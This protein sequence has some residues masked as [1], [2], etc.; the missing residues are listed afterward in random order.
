MHPDFKLINRTISGLKAL[1]QSMQDMF[2]QT[3]QLEEQT[4]SLCAALKTEQ[5]AD[6]LKEIP[7]EDLKNSR[8]G[9]RTQL[10]KEA[11]FHSLHDLWLAGDDELYALSGIGEKQ[12]QAI[13]SITGTFL[14]H[15][16][17]RER[18]RLPKADAAEKGTDRRGDE[19]L[20]LLA[21]YRLAR[22]ICRD[23]KVPFDKH[24]VLTNE[25]IGRIKIRGRLRWLFSGARA[26][27]E[28]LA[29]WEELDAYCSGP[30][31]ERI[32]RFC[33]LYLEAVGISAEDA[34]ADY[35]KN[36]AAYYALL[37]KI[38]G[39]EP[40][41]R[42]VYGSLPQQLAEQVSGVETFLD[43]FRGDLRPY[44]HFGVQYVLH[45]KKVLLGDEMGLGK[46]IQAVGVMVHLNNL[47]E[48][49]RFLIVCP[50]S[51]MANWCREIRKF[52]QI[53]AWLLH[54]PGLEESFSAWEEKGGA[55]VTNYESL[56]RI[57]D[58]IDEHLAL[59]LLVVDEAHYIKNPDAQRTRFL[60][61]LTDESQRILLMSGTPLENKVDEM[62]ELIGFV[63]PDL[64]EKVR[65][66]AGPGRSEEFRE[67]LS[68]G[69]LRRQASQVLEE[70]P[71]LIENEEWCSMTPD[72]TAAYAL[73]ITA[74]NFMGM[75]RVSF[76]SDDAADSSKAQRLSELCSQALEDNK[77]VIVYS[78][79]R[80]TLRKAAA[81]L[82]GDVTGEITGST[83]PAQRQA[84]I[85]RF[86]DTP[87]GSILLCQTQAGGTGLNIQA[88][89]VVIFCEP[90]IK[91]SLE[92]QAI[93]RVY[94]MGQTSSVLVFHL[95]CENTVDE[96]IRILLE[97]KEKE[98]SLYADE[99]AMARAEASLADREWIR[100]VVD[101][102]RSRY[103]PAVY[104]RV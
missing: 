34:R 82:G 86:S 47:S 54:G 36:S 65:T 13:R 56:R 15:L 80:E 28:T 97:E 87:G 76:L 21:R 38:S 68:P 85:D 103:L 10:L 44:Q 25:L 2:T 18:I 61:R 102:Q 52:S 33:S 22:Q 60:K 89:S 81:I 29:A 74:G 101:E 14:S 66:Y 79:F 59:D 63:R 93:A 58:R 57:T 3:Q 27:K 77:K 90:Q 9:I 7:V 55:A 92:K 48:K 95:L 1:E 43:G 39:S 45:Q 91:P 53:S 23:A 99:S 8:A 20:T 88:A 35:R 6:H 19:L 83:P 31:Y 84:L 73:E 26:K 50:A 49:A 17:A 37:E 5:A 30:G 12:V 78:Y 40:P 4:A 42:L 100:Q 51:V 98:F 70:L 72:D 71:D 46:T 67:M 24:H 62:C 64:A 41:S 104:N 96:S 16:S 69:Y 94:R 32:R 75:R 11:G